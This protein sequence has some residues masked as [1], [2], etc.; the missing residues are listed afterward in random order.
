M[1]QV[2]RHQQLGEPPL[3]IDVDFVVTGGAGST[4]RLGFDRRLSP[5]RGPGLLSEV[6][7]KQGWHVGGHAAAAEVDPHRTCADAPT[8]ECWSERA[9]KAQRSPCS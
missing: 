1:P 8:G 2:L 9:V 3:Y 7:P 5:S 4:K 6:Q